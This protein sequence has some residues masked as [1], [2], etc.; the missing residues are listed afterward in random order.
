MG[1]HFPKKSF[2]VR[3]KGPSRAQQPTAFQPYLLTFLIGLPLTFC[4][5]VV[6]EGSG[7]ML[8]ARMLG[9]DHTEAPSRRWMLGGENPVAP[10]DSSAQGFGTQSQSGSPA[11]PSR[12]AR[13]SN[14]SSGGGYNCVVDGD[15]FWSEGQKIR[16]ADI[17]TPETHPARCAEEARL[18]T[19]ATERLKELLSAGPFTLVSIDRDTDK[20]GRKLRI[21]ERNGAS[22]GDALVSEG[23]ARSYSGG[24]REGW[25][26]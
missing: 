16:I 8:W 22:L 17:D 4:A 11:S 3:R 10:Q 1:V 9:S 25:C 19:Q 26:A 7:S 13:F 18:G 24:Y 20:Y 15:T 12:R 23:L 5:L 14:C 6:W 21:V 2:R